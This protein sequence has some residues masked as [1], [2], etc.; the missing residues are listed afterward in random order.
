MFP[1]VNMKA[2]KTAPGAPAVEQ[3]APKTRGRKKAVADAVQ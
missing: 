3:P 2:A 1:A